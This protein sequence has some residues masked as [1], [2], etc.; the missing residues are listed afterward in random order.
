MGC[1]W[2]SRVNTPFYVLSEMINLDAGIG[3]GLSLTRGTSE[4]IWLMRTVKRLR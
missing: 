3:L 2:L 1:P 4:E